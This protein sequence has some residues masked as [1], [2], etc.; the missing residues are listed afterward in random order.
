MARIIA[1][2]SG[3]ALALVMSG[4]SPTNASSCREFWLGVGLSIVLINLSAII[5]S[6]SLIWPE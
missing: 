2:R 3:A 6:S 1:T 5:I 4:P